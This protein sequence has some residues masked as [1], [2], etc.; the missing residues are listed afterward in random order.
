M[1]HNQTWI[2]YKLCNNESKQTYAR[3]KWECVYQKEQ[4]SLILTSNYIIEVGFSHNTINHQSI[5]N[6]FYN[7]NKVVIAVTNAKKKY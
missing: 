6:F 2:K 4:F 3:N 5:A 7:Q 1:V